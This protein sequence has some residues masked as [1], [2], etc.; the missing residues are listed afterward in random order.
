GL[1]MGWGWNG[2]SGRGGRRDRRDPCGLG[3]GR[4][5][6]RRFGARP[7]PALLVVRFCFVRSALG[8]GAQPP[9]TQVS[10]PFP[11]PPGSCAEWFFIRESIRRKRSSDLVEVGPGGG[12]ADRKPR[13]SILHLASECHIGT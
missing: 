1:D 6:R 4:R 5:G 9:W 13:L 7:L 2:E 12:G 3:R 10:F 11:S 8:R